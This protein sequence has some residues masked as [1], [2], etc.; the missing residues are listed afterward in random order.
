M[1]A[2][3]TV[4]PWDWVQLPTWEPVME[5]QCN[6]FAPQIETLP[7]LVRFQHSPPF[8]VINMNKKDPMEIALRNIEK[9]DNILRALAGNRKKRGS[10]N[11]RADGC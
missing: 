1:V 3:R 8:T 11:G 4:N 5:S 6:G 10:L 2:Q 7:E 9:D